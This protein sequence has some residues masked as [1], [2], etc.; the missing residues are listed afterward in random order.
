MRVLVT[1]ARGML[2]Q[3]LCPILEDNAYDVIETTKD[4]MNITDYKLVEAILKKES[5]DIVIHC[6]AYTNVDLAE[7]EYEKAYSIN[8]KGTENIAKAS[9]LI[10]AKVIYISTDYVFDGEKNTP[11]LP[12]DMPNPINNYGKTKYLGE[13]A[14]KKYCKKYYIARTSWLYG[15]H[16][17]NF[18]EK[19][20]SL[21]DKDKLF[22]VDDEVGCPT[23]TIDLSNAIIELF[24]KPFGIYHICGSNS[25]S[26]YGF[27]KEIFKQLGI[28]A[29]LVPCSSNEFKLPAKRPKYS[30]MDND[31]SCRAWEKALK[32]YLSLRLD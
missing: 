11:Y 32:D 19:I 31:N 20:I 21:K 13:E 28:S 8:V 10:D 18:V 6:A 1:G 7:S 26:R 14:I 4:S 22:V 12:N 30:A 29:N 3:D 15:H 9:N 24:N 27:A 25:T 16:S 2:G 5:P 17:N 23:W